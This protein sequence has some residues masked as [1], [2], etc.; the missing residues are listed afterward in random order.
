MNEKMEVG[1][2]APQLAT[3]SAVFEMKERFH[4][5]MHARSALAIQCAVKELDARVTITQLDQTRDGQP[6]AADAKSIM[7]LMMNLMDAVDGC[8]LRAD[9]T[10][11]DAAKA[12]RNLSLLSEVWIPAAGDR[13][14]QAHLP[15]TGR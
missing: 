15:P 6:C 2:A 11:N 4:G 10:G 9:A 8:H 13:L 3:L 14:D 5:R 12:L 7:E 1:S